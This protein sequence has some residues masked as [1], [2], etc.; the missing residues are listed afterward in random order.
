[1]SFFRYFFIACI[2]ICTI[3]IEYVSA[4]LITPEKVKTE[5]ERCINARKDWSYATITE[6]ICP[7]AEFL[8]TN[9]KDISQEVLACTIKMSLE[10]N[11]IDKDAM[12]WATELQKQRNKD[13]IKWN[14]EI[15]KKVYGD[16][17]L[18]KRYLGVCDIKEWKDCAVTTDFFPETTCSDRA[19]AKAAAWKDMGYILAGKGIAKWYQN[20]KDTYIDAVKG[21]Y[22][23]LLDKWNEYKR[24]VDRAVSKFTAYIKNAVK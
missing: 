5:T 12:K 9:G 23:K 22:D 17:G 14:E 7:S 24:I 6:Y 18:E 10:F 16:N 20:D 21:I 19:K 8:S 11:E 4:G 13:P 3:G 15:Q 2:L 1:M